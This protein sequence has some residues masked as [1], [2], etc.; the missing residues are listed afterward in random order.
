MDP[1]ELQ[2][3][4]W[5]DAREEIRHRVRLAT[6]FS[7]A[8]L[9]AAVV[10]CGVQITAFADGHPEALSLRTLL[11]SVLLLGLAAAGMTALV[12]CARHGYRQQAR[13]KALAEQLEL[14]DPPTGPDAP[15]PT[16]LHV[17]LWGVHLAVAT[18]GLLTLCG[19]FATATS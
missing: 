15:A 11:G 4:A 3:A 5:R 6:T 14:T 7:S 1:K 10:I 17:V 9:V 12:S 2:L 16:D 19:A 8:T 18:L 13:A